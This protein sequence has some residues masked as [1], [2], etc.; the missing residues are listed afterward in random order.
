MFPSY[1]SQSCCF[2]ELEAEKA[3]KAV[4][5]GLYYQKKILLWELAELAV[6][7]AEKDLKKIRSPLDPCHYWQEAELEAGLEVGQEV[8]KEPL[9]IQGD[10]R[11]IHCYSA[12]V[13][14]KAESLP[15]QD[16][17]G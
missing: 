14:E 15:Y 4:V 16:P 9:Q 3:E 17:S 8:E 7:E 11:Q 12:E 1:Q 13:A 2:V 6:E 10:L 5:G